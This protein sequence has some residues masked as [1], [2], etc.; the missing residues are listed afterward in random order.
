[1][2]I[3]VSDPTIWS[4]RLRMYLDKSLVYVNALCNRDYEGEIAPGSTVK[5]LNVAE[6]TIEDYDGSLT[7][8]ADLTDE[9]NATLTINQKKAFNFKV[10]DTDQE[11]SVLNLIDQGSK[12]HAY[13]LADTADQYI[14]SLHAGISDTTPDNTYGDSTT[15]IVIG[16]GGSDVAAYDMFLELSQRLDEA[17]V[18]RQDRRIVLPPWLYRRIKKELGGKDSGL[19]DQVQ[20]NGLIGELDGVQIFL[21]NN[22]ANTS[23]AKYKVMMGIPVITYAEAIMKTET[24]RVES[25]FATGVKG[26]H[27]Y[28][29]KLVSPAALALATVS[30]GTL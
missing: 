13:K 29:A 3:T 8:P 5:I 20:L 28:G 11:F 14:A 22:V 19:G 4:T 25:A 1:M 21:S 17:N 15:P 27:V 10:E 30:K 26:L 18:P 2:A 6:G 23:G 12:R 7:A 24:Y 16:G 9:N